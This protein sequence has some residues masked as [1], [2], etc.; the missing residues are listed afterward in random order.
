MENKIDMIINFSIV[1]SGLRNAQITR[2]T[3]YLG[4]LRKYSEKRLAF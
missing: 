4:C 2:K 1:L 3:L